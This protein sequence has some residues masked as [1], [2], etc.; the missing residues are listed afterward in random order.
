MVAWCACGCRCGR[1]TANGMGE[2]VFQFRRLTHSDLR[3][4]GG[5]TMR[6][7]PVVVVEKNA[8]K[9]GALYMHVVP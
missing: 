3:W 7:R 6:P 5:Y 9:R 4:R 8:L 2:V 1:G